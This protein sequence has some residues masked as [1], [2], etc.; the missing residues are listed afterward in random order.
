MKFPLSIRLHGFQNMHVDYIWVI[1]KFEFE[2]RFRITTYQWALCQCVDK[3][4]AHHESFFPC[5]NHFFRFCVTFFG[6]FDTEFMNFFE[7]MLMF[8]KEIDRWFDLS[9]IF[10]HTNNMQ[11]SI[12]PE[13][14]IPQQIAIRCCNKTQMVG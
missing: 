3:K 8:C 11:Y 13:M 5:V 6:Y 7:F 4:W 10:S 14:C 12:C 1:N 2:S 9:H